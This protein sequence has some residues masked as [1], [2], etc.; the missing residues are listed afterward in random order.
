MNSMT[1]DPRISVIIPVYNHGLYLAEAI[2]SVLVQTLPPSE[3]IVVDDGSTD[4]TAETSRSFL[5]QIRYFRQA[6]R[7]LG[8]ARNLGIEASRGNIIAHLDAD[9]IWLPDKLAVQMEAM[10]DRQERALIGGHVESFLSPDLPEDKRAK[11]HCPAQPLPGLSASA[12]IVKR[13][14]YDLIGLY[15][16]HWRI[17]TDLNWLVR[18][19][20]AGLETFIVSRVVMRRRLH[21]EN[22]GLRE[23]DAARNRI[24]V[25]KQALDKRRK[26]DPG[27][28]SGKSE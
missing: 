28:P 15:E 22:S 20:D 19:R 7:G 11:L 18:V 23:R 21:A 1:D 16:T 14:V 26:A 17:G 9:D 6:H 27:N 10:R 25:L 12:L 4:G 24:L 8:S 3:I 2:K 5:P 13:E